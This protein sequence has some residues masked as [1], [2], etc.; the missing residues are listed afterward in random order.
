MSEKRDITKP[1]IFGPG[2][3]FV[4]HTMAY[5]ATTPEKIEA[6]V[7]FIHTMSETLPC[8]ECRNHCSEYVRQNP[9]EKYRLISQNG[10]LIGMFKWSWLFHN[11]V[12]KRLNKSLIDWET[13]FAMYGADSEVCSLK[14]ALG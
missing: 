3:W 7:G 14:C 4:M 6:F 8:I 5:Q 1:D 2:I 13:A 9:P 12:N 11:T 10:I